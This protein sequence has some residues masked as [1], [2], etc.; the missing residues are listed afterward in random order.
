M[1]VGLSSPLSDMTG[2]ALEADAQDRHRSRF[3]V[4]MMMDDG[5]RRGR[6]ERGGARGEKRGEREGLAERFRM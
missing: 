2:T 1:T 5:G 4:M 6:E 3:Q